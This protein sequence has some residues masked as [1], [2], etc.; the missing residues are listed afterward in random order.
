MKKILFAFVVLLLSTYPVLAQESDIE[1]MY[2]DFVCTT[3]ECL[4]EEEEVVVEEE[5]VL[6]T[7]KYFNLEL[8]PHT[9]SPWNKSVTYTLKI[10]PLIDSPK[11]QILWEVPSTLSV[12]TL[13]SE[14][15]NL[16]KG[17]TYEFKGRIKPLRTGTYTFAVNVIS[18]Q[19]D[20]NYTNTVEQDISFNN[21]LVVNPVDPEYQFANIVMIIV[22]VVL[23]G[24][25]GV[26]AYFGIKYGLKRLKIW[27]TPPK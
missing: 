15:V 12:R 23:L 16:E 22:Y 6:D 10:T 19:T 18:W 20:V 25:V 7:T 13:H 9:Q 17:L 3:E 11:T 2:P 26:G 1:D 24:A 5:P 27:F 8:I 21:N 14:F 4:T